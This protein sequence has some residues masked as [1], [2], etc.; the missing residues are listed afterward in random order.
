M[1]LPFGYTDFIQSNNFL[2]KNNKRKFVDVNNSYG[3][4]AKKRKIV[5]LINKKLIIKSEAKSN[6]NKK[7]VIKSEVESN[8]NMNLKIKSEVESKNLEIK[9]ENDYQESYVEANKRILD[10][11]AFNDIEGN[12][13]FCNFTSLYVKD[14]NPFTDE[15]SFTTDDTSLDAFYSSLPPLVDNNN[16]SSISSFCYYENDY[17]F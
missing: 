7:L 9:S 13:A 4:V 16:V 12:F 10:D 3:N 5:D 1:P 14:E 11:L 17:F 8:T 6:D 2:E 15:Y